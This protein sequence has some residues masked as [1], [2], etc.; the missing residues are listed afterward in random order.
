MVEKG[1]NNKGFI[2][3]FPLQ[4]TKSLEA[5]VWFYDISHKNGIIQKWETNK[6]LDEST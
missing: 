3:S 4:N 5:F 2:G 6:A 1:R